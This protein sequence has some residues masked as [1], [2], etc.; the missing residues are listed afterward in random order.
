MA[1]GR[2]LRDTRSLTARTEWLGMEGASWTGKFGEEGEVGN[3]SSAGVGGLTSACKGA[4][5]LPIKWC[6]CN[7]VCCYTNATW[8]PCMWTPEEGK[9]GWSN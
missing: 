7:R 5:T 4:F 6:L 2:R 1:T 9:S 3:A 8:F